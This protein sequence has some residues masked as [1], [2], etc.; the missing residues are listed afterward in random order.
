VEDTVVM[1]FDHVSVLRDLQDREVQRVYAE[2]LTRL[3]CNK[4]TR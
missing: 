3:K 2:V 4:V 1:Q